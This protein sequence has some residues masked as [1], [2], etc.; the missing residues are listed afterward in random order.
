MALDVMFSNISD[1]YRTPV[2]FFKAM[3]QKFGGF[4]I[5]LA[6]S[7]K[8][9][10]AD[11]H[12]GP[13]H[14]DAECRDALAAN[15]KATVDS[16]EKRPVGWLNPPYSQCAA[17]VQKAADERER[18]FCTVM[19]LPHRSDTRWYHAHIWDKAKQRPRKGVGI[20]PIQGRLQFYL[21]V[22]DPMRQAVHRAHAN[23]TRPT[24]EA[25]QRALE[26]TISR[27][28]G[29]PVLIVRAILHGDPEV[30]AGAPFPS[31]VVSFHPE[32]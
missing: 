21:D 29:L 4:S 3:E 20:D 17:F 10:V 7:R 14:Y 12:F 30:V 18:G 19:L 24:D 13:D 22:T 15:W 6:A 2:A 23:A 8:N 1:D 11:L 31:V 26:K 9:R 16:W 32:G 27:A 5:D 25:G 28:V